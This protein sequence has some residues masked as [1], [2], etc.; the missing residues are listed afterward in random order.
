M[1]SDD[2]SKKRSRQSDAL[3]HVT[4][5]E[6]TYGARA[7]SLLGQDRGGTTKHFLAASA[8]RGLEPGRAGH[9]VY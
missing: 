1:R 9:P 2:A 8:D 5:L 6:M 4:E 3:F 7:D